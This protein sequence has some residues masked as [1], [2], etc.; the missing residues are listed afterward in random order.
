M[1]KL[2]AALVIA[3]LIVTVLLSAVVTASPAAEPSIGPRPPGQVWSCIPVARG[4]SICGYSR[5]SSTYGVAKRLRVTG[6][7]R[8]PY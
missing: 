6:Y 4:A 8:L 1:K 7:G 3:L 2:A 5:Q